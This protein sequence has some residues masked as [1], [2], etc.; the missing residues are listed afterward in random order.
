[1]A[2]LKL[3]RKGILLGSSLWIISLIASVCVMLYGAQVQA[4]AET[5]INALTMQRDGDKAVMAGASY[6][7]LQQL[8]QH[9]AKD[10]VKHFFQDDLG[11]KLLA[12]VSWEDVRSDVDNENS[13]QPSMSEGT[14]NLEKRKADTS[15]GRV[16]VEVAGSLMDYF[17]LIN[18]FQEQY[19]MVVVKPVIIQR[20]DGMGHMRFQLDL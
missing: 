17:T 8:N 18:E 2:V 19:P 10:D 15:R 5:S 9:P 3:P 12:L 7:L 11:G 4:D 16:T 20:Q 6:K 14:D 13:E 1:M